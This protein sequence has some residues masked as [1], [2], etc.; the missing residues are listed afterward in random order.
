[1]FPG[2]LRRWG[3]VSLSSG[4]FPVQLG[5][6]TSAQAYAFQG[7]P[8]R[9]INHLHLGF[10]NDSHLTRTSPGPG[11]SRQIWQVTSFPEHP[12]PPKF[13]FD[14]WWVPSSRTPSSSLHIQVY[15]STRCSSIPTSFCEQPLALD[16]HFPPARYCAGTFTTLSQSILVSLQGS[17]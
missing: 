13:C 17:Y 10:S 9:T 4:P 8:L 7:S 12:N 2:V 16:E 15:G 14:M 11:E 1:M 5:V 6:A 3:W